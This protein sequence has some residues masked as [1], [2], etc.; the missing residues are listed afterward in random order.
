MANRQLLPR[1]TQEDLLVRYQTTEADCVDTDTV[2]VGAAG[3]VELLLSGVG[4]GAYT[5][6]GA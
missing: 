6:F 5:C 3:A 1:T 4:R 2:N